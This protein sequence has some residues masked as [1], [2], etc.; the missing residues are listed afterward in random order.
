MHLLWCMMAASLPFEACDG[1][2][3]KAAN[4]S[5]RKYSES[6]RK[7]LFG[8]W[9]D[10]DHDCRNTR[11]EILAA[12]SQTAV[13]GTCTIKTGRWLDPYTGR[14]F[15]SAK[16][17]EID[18]LIPV[19]EAYR[20]GAWKWTQAQ[21]VAFYNDTSLLVIAS[22]TAN[23]TKRDKDPS[24]WLPPDTTYSLEYIQR[25]ARGKRTYGLTA[26]AKER[27]FLAKYL[28]IDGTPGFS[29]GSR[30]VTRRPLA[31]S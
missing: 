16:A 15:D 4:T 19:A 24:Q 12:R 31:F 3:A 20:S 29:V 14:T 7:A 9:I 27:K 17:L 28:P 10:S 5:C 30:Y 8:D 21:R 1:N 25:W 2:V 18:H 13:T 23:A 6:I 11:A 22:A 26:D